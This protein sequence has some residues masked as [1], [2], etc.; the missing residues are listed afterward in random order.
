MRLLVNKSNMVGD[1][2]INL[3]KISLNLFNYLYAQ[4]RLGRSAGNRPARI[5][6]RACN[7]GSGGKG[8]RAAEVYRQSRFRA[9]SELPGRN[10]SDHR[11]SL[12][13][14][15]LEGRAFE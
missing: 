8:N 1:N 6:V 14:K 15:N 12:E 10:A 4:R 11:G 5:K 2:L 7:L 3:K 13:N 9:V